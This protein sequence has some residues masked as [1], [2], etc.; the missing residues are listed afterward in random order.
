LSTRHVNT[1]HII[2]RNLFARKWLGWRLAVDNLIVDLALVLL[3]RFLLSP[4]QKAF[5]N[6]SMSM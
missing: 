6:A 1:P 4:W 5:P 2:D 3:I